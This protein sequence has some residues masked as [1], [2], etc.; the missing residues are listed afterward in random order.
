MRIIFFGNTKYSVIGADILHRELGLSRIVTLPD[1]PDKRSRIVPNP[2]KQFASAN[3]IPVSEVEKITSGVIDQIEALQPDFF[4]VEDYG[5]IL[6]EK[7]LTVPR[8]APLNIHHSLLPKYR[9]PSPAPSAILAGEKISGVTVIHMN[10]RMD[11]GDIYAQTNYTLS[12]SD[13]TDSLLTILNQL[14]AELAV[15][16]INDILQKNA[17]RKPQD[18]N[19]ATYTHFLKKSDGRI[20]M[21]NPPDPEKLDRM[22]R[23]YYPWPT[24]WTKLDGKIIKFYPERKLQ[25]EGKNIISLKEFL[26]GYPQFRQQLERLFQPKASS[27]RPMVSFGPDRPLDEA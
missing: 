27:Q 12:E 14:G 13:T 4:V 6:P 15:S 3:K 2:V 16:T 1:K 7:L 25:M 18:E 9:G 10:K 21:N 20:D 17:L 5:L 22:I 26:N 19:E 11:A 24:V 23:A 8:Y